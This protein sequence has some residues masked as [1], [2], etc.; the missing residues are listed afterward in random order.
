MKFIKGVP[1]T[2]TVGTIIDELKD[3]ENKTSIKIDPIYQRNIVWN[4]SQ[5]SKFINSVLKGIMPNNIILNSTNKDEL[6]CIDGKQ[7][8][9][10]IK[11]FSENKFPVEYDEKY[12][13][14]SEVPDKVD[15]A[16]LFGDK[17]LE[18]VECDKLDKKILTTYK[19]QHINIVTYDNLS[20]E[21]QVDIFQR[22]QHG[23]KLTEGEIVTSAI[24]K[25]DIAKKFKTKCKKLEKEV[26]QDLVKKK[27]NCLE[28]K[29]TKRDEHLKFVSCLMCAISQKEPEI[30][31]VAKSRKYIQD[32]KKKKFTEILDR[33][34][35][36]IKKTYGKYI[37]EDIEKKYNNKNVRFITLLL[38]HNNNENIEDVDDDNIKR[39]KNAFEKMCYNFES[40]NINLTSKKKD[41]KE[42]YEHMKKL[43]NGDNDNESESENESDDDDEVDK[44]KKNKKNVDKDE[45]DDDI[46]VDKN[47]K[48]KKNV[49]KD[50]KKKK[51]KKK[52]EKKKDKKKKDDK[53]EKKKND[54]KKKDDKQKKKEKKEENNESDDEKDENEEDE[55]IE[56]EEVQDDNTASVVSEDEESDGELSD[57][58]SDE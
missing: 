54:K 13:Y 6:I 21:E 36:I 27:T 2:K 26:I 52:D 11:E 33:S 7:R 47:K 37:F 17:S 44:N 23:S 32:L 53:N 18:K 20:Y 30:S 49:E 9:T 29:K 57:M 4:T 42:I 31:G 16:K 40:Y 15:L 35:D 38:L 58:E 14:Y 19:K 41:V 12:Y 24:M 3:G 8:L 34:N 39:L 46:E 50:E 51:N 55:I 1:T 56:V 45:S 48:N 43:Y 5:K 10:S 28:L 25:E 22:L